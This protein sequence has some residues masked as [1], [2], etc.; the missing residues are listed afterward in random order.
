MIGHVEIKVRLRRPL[1]KQHIE[2]IQEKF[3]IID[4]PGDPETVAP[5]KEAIAPPQARDFS[6]L[7]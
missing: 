3:L 4:G 5:K 7:S 6:F 2:K 1:I